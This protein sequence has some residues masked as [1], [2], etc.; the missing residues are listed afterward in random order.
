MIKHFLIL[1]LSL[2]CASCSTF[3]T[4]EQLYNAAKDNYFTDH[5]I[6]IDSSYFDTKSYSFLKLSIGDKPPVILSLAYINYPV[7]EWV[8]EDG[9]SIFT[10]NGRVIQTQGLKHDVVTISSSVNE[11]TWTNISD[12]QLIHKVNFTNPIYRLASIVE[13]KKFVDYMHINKFTDKADIKVK[14]FRG[15]GSIGHIGWNYKNLYYANDQTG[16]IEKSVQHIHPMLEPLH[17]QYY[18]KYD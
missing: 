6:P 9:I 3:F 7:F 14:K 2:S 17:I 18:F 4:T 16:I 1:F 15:F 13:D 8:S 10:E 12:D 11:T 5:T